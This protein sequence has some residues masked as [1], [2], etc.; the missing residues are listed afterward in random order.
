MIQA[1]IDLQQQLEQ[2]SSDLTTQPL[3]ND[4]PAIFIETSDQLNNHPSEQVE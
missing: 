3:F 4:S 1:Q 2:A